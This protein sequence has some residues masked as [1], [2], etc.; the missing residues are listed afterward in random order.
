MN[1]FTIYGYF[2]SILKHL[3]YLPFDPSYLRGSD[4]ADELEHELEE[5]AIVEVVE[6]AVCALDTISINDAFEVVSGAFSSVSDLSEESKGFDDGCTSLPKRKFFAKL[7]FQ[8][9][10]KFLGLFWLI[11]ML[12]RYHNCTF[13]LFF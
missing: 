2:V 5:F 13:F 4:I 12:K 10:Y 3:F 6:D 11:I 1:Y 9:C 8:L 7:K